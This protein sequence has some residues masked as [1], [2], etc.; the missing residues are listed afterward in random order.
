MDV[1]PIERPAGSFQQ[2]VSADRIQAVCRRALGPDTRVVSAVEMGLGMY[3][4]TYRVTVEGVT[5][6]VI[7]RFAPAPDRQFVSERELMRNE[8]ATLPHLAK[9]A[10]LMP[11]VI[12]ADWSHELVDR[13]YMVQTLLD[14]VPAAE[15]LST[16]PRRSR[17]GFFR[18]V[19]K[20]ARTVHAVR[21]TR[22]GPVAGPAYDTWSQA[23]TASLHD[24]AADLDGLGLDAADLR[25][26]AALAVEHAAVLDGITEPRLLSGDLW[27][28][29]IM[30]AADA[31]EPVISGV[32]DLD[33]TLWGDP[34]AD[35]PIRMAASKRDERVAFWEAYGERDESPAAVWRSLIYEIR[36]LGAVRLER[37]RLGGAVGDSYDAVAAVLAE[38]T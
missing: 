15:G 10:P 12:A 2:S 14:G 31:P 9:I 6:P 32:F 37:H 19:G 27:T 35:W 8:Y 17:T 33:R 34:A 22:F 18:Q 5:R 36:H 29:N 13:D 1:Q 21:G 24:I 16:Y 11:R 26:A 25:K 28:V 3:N 38:L 4:T 23:V 7:V 30:I 20:I